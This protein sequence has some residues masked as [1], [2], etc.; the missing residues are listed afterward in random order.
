MKAYPQALLLL[1]AVGSSTC[2]AFQSP[3]GSSF[4]SRGIS[5][6][7]LKG[8]LDD[9]T[10]DLKAKPA[11][12]YDSS[13]ESLD[14]TAYARAQVVN[15]GPG[16]LADFKDFNDEFDGGDGQMGVAGDGNTGLE[17]I[18]SGPTLAST[19]N[20][21]KMMSAKNAWGTSSG[22]AAKLMEENKDMDISRAQQLENW[23]NQREVWNKNQFVKKMEIADDVRQS[24]DVDWRTLAKFGVERN[25]DFNLDEAFGDVVPAD[26]IEET[27]S[28]NSM[29]GRPA[30][31]TIKLKNEYMGFAD[32]RAAFTADSS[33]DYSVTPSEGSISSK[34][35]TEYIVKFKPSAPGVAEALLV[36]ETED[37][38]KTWHFIG[39]T[40]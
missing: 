7:V 33:L 6:I 17:K 10:N 40:A 31:H 29:I 30:A 8:Y 28:M 35:A 15:A 27:I 9:L 21:S 3:L 23:Q 16:S 19:M 39:S 36:I 20:K 24:A 22:Y 38:K 13:T 4:A 14:A 32:F 1:V 2:A 34:E 26:K 11:N 18:G 5:K 12:E 25:Q 37:F